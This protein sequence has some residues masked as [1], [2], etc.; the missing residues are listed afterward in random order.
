MKYISNNQK[1]DSAIA[2]FANAHGHKSKYTLYDSI[3]KIIQ[4]IFLQ[5]FYLEDF[6]SQ[7]LKDLKKY[8]LTDILTDIINFIQ[9]K[10]LFST[11]VTTSNVVWSTKN[12]QYENIMNSYNEY[13]NI[14][15]KYIS[16]YKM[17]QIFNKQRNL[18]RK[19]YKLFRNP[20]NTNNINIEKISLI[21]INDE[22]KLF[23]DTYLNKLTSTKLK[24]IKLNNI[25]CDND[26]S[27]HNTLQTNCQLTTKIKN[28]VEF[29][30]NIL[31]DFF[32]SDDDMYTVD[33]HYEI[34]LNEIYIKYIDYYLSLMETE[35]NFMLKTNFLIK[36]F[37]NSIEKEKLK[38]IYERNL[39]A[40]RLIF[41]F[42]KNLLQS[43]MDHDNFWIHQLINKNTYD[44]E[45]SFDNLDY[46][47]IYVLFDLFDN[48][49]RIHNIQNIKQLSLYENINIIKNYIN[50]NF[51]DT[52]IINKFKREIM[53]NILDNMIKQKET[54]TS[55][56]LILFWCLNYNHLTI[57][58][59]SCRRGDINNEKP[60]IIKTSS[61]N[62]N[63]IKSHK[64]KQLSDINNINKNKNYKINFNTVMNDIKKNKQ[65]QNIVHNN[66]KIS[67][68]KKR[69][70]CPNGEKR[71]KKTG[72]CEK[73]SMNNQLKNDSK[74]SN[75]KKRK[76][77]PNGEKRNKKT[78]ICEKNK[79]K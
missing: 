72:I 56:I 13:N 78:G 29:N 51:N 41:F 74:I 26:Y 12:T 3:N 18:L 39:F 20:K 6:S 63:L 58:L 47:G 37:K 60:N 27:F 19:E 49:Q 64:S 17:K 25:K 28:D 52:S 40:L 2:V 75:T 61:D 59:Q 73:I 9:E 33:I 4:E 31:K 24:S 66:A 16:S 34:I 7:D 15:N 30:L 62:I 50:N 11:A 68:T 54:S 1:I 55:K 23:N 45:L 43:S 57:Y 46:P 70:R 76:R 42:K 71:N 69:K 14:N 10:V 22:I 79:Y 44:I 48:K 53:S 38:Q 21:N 8:H 77:C 35:N 5:S 36:E 67:N 32:Y 65:I